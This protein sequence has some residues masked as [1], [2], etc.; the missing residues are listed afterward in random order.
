MSINPVKPSHLL[1]PSGLVEMHPG[2]SKNAL[3]EAAEPEVCK[4]FI[5]N[6]IIEELVFIL[7]VSFY[8]EF[9]PGDAKSESEIT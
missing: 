4:I 3:T 5:V 1:K 7:N 2:N 8:Q 9:L 6:F